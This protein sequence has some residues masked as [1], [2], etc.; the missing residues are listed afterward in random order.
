[1]RAFAILSDSQGRVSGGELL[2]A[3][4]FVVEVC[5]QQ[6]KGPPLVRQ[7]DPETGLWL[8]PVS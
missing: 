2:A 6:V 1:V 7:P 5:I 8:W 3:E 4:V